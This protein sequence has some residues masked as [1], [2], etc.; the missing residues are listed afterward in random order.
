M[1][2]LNYLYIL[3]FTLS[4]SSL[5]AQICGAELLDTGNQLKQNTK[6]QSRS[7][8]GCDDITGLSTFYKIPIAIHVIP[9]EFESIAWPEDSDLE[10]LIERANEFLAPHFEL[11]PVVNTCDGSIS[12]RPDVEFNVLTFE[13]ELEIKNSSKFD[14][15]SVLNLWLVQNIDIDPLVDVSA[16]TFNPTS[17]SGSLFEER[18]GIAMEKSLNGE[19]LAHEVGHYLGLLHIWGRQENNE[20]ENCHNSSEDCTKGD[21][22]ADTPPHLVDW[23]F[24]NDPCVLTDDLREDIENGEATNFLCDLD[25]S[26]AECHNIMTFGVNRLGLTEGQFDRM[27]RVKNEFRPDV[28]AQTIGINIEPI[29]TTSLEVTWWLGLGAGGFNLKYK[30]VGQNEWIEI[31]VDGEYTTSY[32]LENLEPGTLYQVSVQADCGGIVLEAQLATE[33]DFDL[34]CDD[35]VPSQN[36]IITTSQTLSHFIISGDLIVESGILTINSDLEF[37]DNS[38]ILIKQNAKVIV[39]GAILTKCPNAD[40]WKGVQLERRINN[41]STVTPGGAIELKNGAVIEYA[42]IGINTAEQVLVNGMPYPSGGGVVTMN[43]SVIRE[44]GVG[45]KFGPSDFRVPSQYAIGE[46]STITN[47]SLFEDCDHA[48]ELNKNHGLSVEESIFQNNCGLAIEAWNSAFSANSSTFLCEIHSFAEYHNIHASTITNNTFLNTQIFNESQGNAQQMLISGN[49]FFSASIYNSGELWFDI[50]GNDFYDADGYLD[51]NSTGKALS[52]F[53]QGNAFYNTYEANRNAGVNDMEYLIN[54]FESTDIAD[55]FLFNNASIAVQQ[56]VTQLSAGNYFS[57]TGTRIESESSADFFTYYTQDFNYLQ[58]RKHPTFSQYY[59]VMNCDVEANQS[60]GTNSN[61]QGNLPDRH[62]H[63]NP[64]IGEDLE[65]FI[66]TIQAEIDRLLTDTS[67]SPWERE[68]LIARYRKCIDKYTKIIALEIIQQEGLESAINFLQGQEGIRYQ[69]LAYSLMVRNLELARA[70]SF[71]NG[72][73]INS[74]EDSDFVFT[75]N[76]YLDYLEQGDDYILSNSD[77]QTLKNKGEKANPLSGFVRSIYYLMTGERI[78]LPMPD[79]EGGRIRSK[80]NANSSNTKGLVFPNPLNSDEFN[81]NLE[82]YKNYPELSIEVL[83]IQG[84]VMLKQNMLEEIE[85]IAIPNLQSGIYVL[86]LSDANGQLHM[87]KFVKL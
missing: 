83:S 63:C 55:I 60:C 79:Y 82:D 20:I 69:Y 25:G 73:I 56:G 13:N 61:I 65:E 43:N 54:C 68:W 71:L 66:A 51:F 22:V 23:P 64:Q 12:F 35:C 36:T 17:F 70:R 44:C 15:E 77:K 58:S 7:I 39:D 38:R 46:L 30:E 10:I 29:S 16:F 26:L 67:V 84:S 81:V 72:L 32:L 14:R 1:K 45:I 57:T 49:R 37:R 74:Q 41:G 4:C 19:T 40:S 86:R 59:D 78:I 87:E 8:S 21:R 31:Y 18:D 50:K 28:D 6:S 75:Q 48:I 52:N 27:I 2:F 80:K 85:R 3:L 9:D 33:C 47:E 76:I 42:E 34:L 62:F 5:F 53:V 11:V 24:D